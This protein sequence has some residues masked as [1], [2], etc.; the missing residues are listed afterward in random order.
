MVSAEEKMKFC[1]ELRNASEVAILI[2][3]F[4]YVLSVASYCFISYFSLLN[5]LTAS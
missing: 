3:A 5:A 2:D 1:P 4:S